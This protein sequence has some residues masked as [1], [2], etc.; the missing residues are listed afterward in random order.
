[1]HVHPGCRSH[2][3]GSTLLTAAIERAHG[4]GCYR[5]QLT[6]NKDRPDAHRFYARHGFQLGHHGFK[7]RLDSDTGVLAQ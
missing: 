6:S 5:I 4:F 1:M 2:G 3:I 7:L